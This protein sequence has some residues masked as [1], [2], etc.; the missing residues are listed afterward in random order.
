MRVI[1]ES[2]GETRR[3][4]IGELTIEE[5]KISTFPKSGKIFVSYLYRDLTEN[6]AD[7]MRN[8]VERG[9]DNIVVISGGE[10]SGKSNLA[11]NLCKA[12]DPDF[13]VTKQY[14]YSVEDLKEKLREG[15]DFG[16]IWWLDEG[17][18]IANNRDWNTQDSKDI[19]AILEM[20]RSRGWTL[21]MC[22]PHWERLDIYIRENRMRY[23]LSC[24]P[25]S[26]EL[27]GDLER[28]YYELRMRS[29]SGSTMKTVGFGTYPP[30]PPEEKAVYEKIKLSSQ[31]RKI[32][33][34]TER[35][36][37]PGA[38]YKAKYE[39]GQRRIGDAAKAL[40]DSGKYSAEELT[41]MLGFEK[42]QDFRNAVCKAK[43]RM[44][45]GDDDDD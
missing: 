20:M 9:Y 6:L 21:I 35:G 43:K 10:G 38:K 44:E 27:S 8:H 33:E 15:D 23:L 32:R 17:S 11:W 22:I 7:H 31:A 29:G 19:I 2:R 41:S 3:T 24:R 40:W 28:G 30:I 4:P 37:K 12:M 36:T 42:M 34:V 25:M 16:A 14:V 26:W 39:E 45:G 18:N 13:D 1:T 5:S